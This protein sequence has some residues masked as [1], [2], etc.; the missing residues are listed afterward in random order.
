[1][2]DGLKRDFPTIIEEKRESCVTVAFRRGFEGD[3]LLF[4][5]LPTEQATGLAC[6]VNA[7]FFP[8]TSRKTIDFTG[9]DIRVRWNQAALAAAARAAARVGELNEVLRAESLWA[10]VQRTWKV[11]IQEKTDWLAPFW[12]EL[13]K[14]QPPPLW[15]ATEEWS[16]PR[17]AYQAFDEKLEGL[18]VLRDLGLKLVHP[19]LRPFYSSLQAL[20]VQQLTLTACIEFLRDLGLGQKRHTEQLPHVIQE[21]ARM[22]ALRDLLTTFSVPAN[23][24]SEL[25]SLALARGVDGAWWP[26]QTLFRGDA[27]TISLFTTMDELPPLL[28]DDLGEPLLRMVGEFGVG[29]ALA[30]LRS[31]SGATL[32]L[33]ANEEPS[34]C[35]TML[36][37]FEDRKAQFTTDGLKKSL[38]ALPLFPT[39]GAHRPLSELSVPGDFEDPIGMATL[40]DVKR[41]GVGVDFLHYLGAGELTFSRFVSHHAPHAFTS[42]LPQHKKNH[43]TRL[44]ADRVWSLRSFPE[45]GQALQSVP[46]VLCSDGAYRKPEHVYLLSREVIALLG[47]VAFAQIPVDAPSVRELYVWLGVSVHPRWEDIYRRICQTTA[48]PPNEVSITWVQQ[49]FA[50]LHARHEDLRLWFDS[51]VELPWLPA[52]GKRDR[53]YQGRELFAAFRQHLFESQALFIDIPRADQQAATDTLLRPLKVKMDP[54]TVQIVRHLV[55]LAEAGT[56]PNN[57]I[58]AV[59]SRA[60]AEL[61]AIPI[62]AHLKQIRCLYA[63]GLYRSPREVYWGPHPFGEMRTQLGRE[64]RQYDALFQAL[65]VR[66]QPEASDYRDVLLEVSRAAGATNRPLVP[67][68]RSVVM[69]CWRR[70]GTG[71]NNQQTVL[72]ELG[73]SKTYPDPSGCLAEPRQL[74]I[75]DAPQLA[76]RFARLS[77]HIVERVEGVHSA[78]LAAGAKLLSAAVQPRLVECVDEVEDVGLAAILERRRLLISRVLGEGAPALP[79]T[80]PRF[81]RS[82]E[83]AVQWVIGAFNRSYE[84]PVEQVPAIALREE[85]AATIYF[86]AVDGVIPWVPLARELATLLAPGR[87]PGQLA[88]ALKEVVAANTEEAASRV[89]DELGFHSLL[90]A[91]PPPVSSTPA[92]SLGIEGE[93]QDSGRSLIATDEDESTEAD[94]SVVREKHASNASP[95]AAAS[96]AGTALSKEG[97]IK[98][99]G[100]SPIGTAAVESVISEEHA[101]NT[102]APAAGSRGATSKNAAEASQSPS[103]AQVTGHRTGDLKRLPLDSPGSSGAPMARERR[104]A[105]GKSSRLRTYVAPAEDPQPSSE[106]E[107]KPRD[108]VDAAGIA[109]VLEHELRAGRFPEEMHHLNPGY[110]I[111]SRDAQ[112]RVVRLIEVKST[113]GDWSNA[114]MSHTQFQTALSRG[115]LFWLY[116]VERADQDEFAVNCIQDPARKADQF[117]FDDGWRGLHDPGS[118]VTPESGFILRITDLPPESLDV[119]SI[120]PPEKNLEDL[121]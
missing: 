16:E 82:G 5:R 14:A 8:L 65:G 50:H 63:S 4:A 88:A 55:F 21:A 115:D 24:K 119:D 103:R 58:Y 45:A 110:D 52:V 46:S 13:T 19:T 7:D 49:V 17:N 42:A 77:R 11:V 59:L 81:V 78:L 84:T 9:P 1:V 25:S 94:E 71:E 104:R 96:G 29:R 80:F 54:A 86:M 102:S 20:G 38:A 72:L 79:G 69:E 92:T 76:A 41:S 74:F 105:H 35:A 100:P 3:G 117:I 26:L 114:A 37:W 30:F 113:K 90:R 120:D 12:T 83:L 87:E 68:E 75:G 109:R 22:I 15:L 93:V 10:S 39:A 27:A 32:S 118:G 95:P 67:G 53:W 121:L 66:E 28:N 91:D 85:S 43:L 116:V 56:P 31:L 89:L 101:S 107:P 48:E 47:E 6:H 2:A 112:K 64:M 62:V 44:L 98:D 23:M 60:A 36:R 99:S 34:R 33:W 111:E 97:E 70:L 106:A 18:A 108:P 57:D 61:A 51:L 40:V 73:R